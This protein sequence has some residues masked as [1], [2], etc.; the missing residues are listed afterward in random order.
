MLDLL[1]RR[2]DR[3]GL[4]TV[5]PTGIFGDGTDQLWDDGAHRD[6][7]AADGIFANTYRR[8][9]LEGTYTWRVEVN[10]R[11]P[12]GD[13]FNRVITRAFW[14]GVGVDPRRST[15]QVQI[16]E[17]A[18]KP[19]QRTVV[20]TVRPVDT[21][22]ELLGPFRA[23]VVQIASTVG[24]FVPVGSPPQY[25]IVYPQPDGGDLVSYYDGSYSRTLV[26]PTGAPGSVKI[27]VQ[28]T[29]FP[30]TPLP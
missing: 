10:G 6:G 28:G 30:D 9:E 8:L 13:R 21:Q 17:R 25:G 23:S 26:Y 7:A 18:S 15:V 5:T 2:R 11:T 24:K 1:L 14:V 22:G 4:S 12:A 29:P 19:G 27:T 16:Q 3:S 20:I